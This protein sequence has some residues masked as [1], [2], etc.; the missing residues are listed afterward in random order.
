MTH[1]IFFWS[2]MS[3]IRGHIRVQ[4]YTILSNETDIREDRIKMKKSLKESHHM[5]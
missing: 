1:V 2:Q 5:R 3:E 4:I